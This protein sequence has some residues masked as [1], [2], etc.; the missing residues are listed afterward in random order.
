MPAP[1]FIFDKIAV[2]IGSPQGIAL[3]LIPDIKVIFDAGTI[4]TGL[5]SAKR[6]RQGQAMCAHAL[7]I[8]MSHS[9]RR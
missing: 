2:K 1:Q 7:L 6:C 3:P 8:W 9:Q 4:R 5:H